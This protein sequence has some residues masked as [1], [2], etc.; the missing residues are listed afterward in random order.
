M[1]NGGRWVCTY[2]I[3][4]VTQDKMDQIRHSWWC[5]K[6][7]FIFQSFPTTYWVL[8]TALLPLCQAGEWPAS[9]K[10]A[11]EIYF[12]KQ[13]TGQESQFSAL[14]WVPRK[15]GYP[16]NHVYLE[17]LLP[18]FLVF[19]GECASK[20]LLSLETLLTPWTKC[21]CALLGVKLLMAS[22]RKS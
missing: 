5:F 20:K 8:L 17:K 11:L 13:N 9:W 22:S 19:L 14:I 6:A 4:S 18:G 3:T 12:R 16:V 7:L 10:L 21:R 1:W 2:L 15:N